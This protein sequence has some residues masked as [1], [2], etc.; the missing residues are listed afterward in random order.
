MTGTP[1]PEPVDRSFTLR[2]SIWIG[3]AP[4]RVWRAI[5]EREELARWFVS[6]L[7][8]EV[9]AGADVQFVFD[10]CNCRMPG[11][12]LALDHGRRISFAFGESRVTIEIEAMDGGTLVRLTDEELPRDPEAVAGQSEGWS[13]YLC[14]LKVVIEVGRDLRADQ[15]AGTI[16][17]K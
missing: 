2:Q 6:D 7:A 14:N 1:R 10:S 5:S 3:A 15:P 4:E 11:R 9:R 17:P 13:A 12:I 16:L 8:G